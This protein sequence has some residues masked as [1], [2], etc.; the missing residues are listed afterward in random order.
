MPTIA[1]MITTPA[2]INPVMAPVLR[3]LA[4]E[5]AASVLEGSGDRP[6]FVPF[7]T[8][9]PSDGEGVMDV[10]TRDGDDEG[11]GEADGKAE[12]AADGDGFRFNE[13]AADGVAAA[14][15]GPL[16]ASVAMLL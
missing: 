13:G 8:L 14:E 15:G 3:P 16:G 11:D 7:P 4:L 12:G 5:D 1:P 9:G 10:N 6:L 2:I